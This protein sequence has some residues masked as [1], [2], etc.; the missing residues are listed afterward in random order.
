MTHRTCAVDCCRDKTATGCWSARCSQD[1][2]FCLVAPVANGRVLA[3]GLRALQADD[4]A[5][6]GELLVLTD[7]T[8]S[9]EASDGTPHL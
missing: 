9:V 3:D 1:A 6:D 5:I 2:G 7:E 8:S 4:L